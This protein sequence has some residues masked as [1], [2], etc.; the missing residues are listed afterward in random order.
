MESFTPEIVLFILAEL[1]KSIKIFAGISPTPDPGG[2][3]FEK[4]D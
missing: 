3:G 4:A 2:I 1:S